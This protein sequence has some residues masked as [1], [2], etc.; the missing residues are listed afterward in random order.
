MQGSFQKRVGN[1]GKVTWTC[2]V[3]G[4]PDPVTG[5]RKQ[6]RL[7][8]STKRELQEQVTAMLHAAKSGAY[9]AP[10]GQLLREY[11]IGW[12]AGHKSQIRET[13][14]RSY[15]QLIRIHV[16]PKL[17]N[18]P[19]QKLTASALE[20][21]YADR[22]ASGLSPRTVQYLH[23]VIRTALQHAFRLGT[24]VRNVADMATAPRAP[25][26]QVQTWNSDQLRAFLGAAG[27]DGY[28]PA[29]LMAASTGLRRG[30]LLGLRWE[31]VDLAK[32]R[33][34]VRQAI[35]EVGSTLRVQEPK[36]KSGRRVVPFG[37]AV[38]TALKAHQAKQNERRLKLGTAWRGNAAPFDDLVFTTAVGGPIGPQNFSHRFKA[39][40]VA[41]GLP[42]VRL[43]DVRHAH[44][45][46][47][48]RDGI[49]AKVVSER[50]GH[51]SIALTLDTYSHVL[52]DMQDGAV[53]ATEAALFGPVSE[54]M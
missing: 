1:T 48:L 51:A 10:T 29:W 22:L 9:V 33:L 12:L 46:Q 53:L 52:P 23:R 16:L 34:H 35:V 50:L 39:L 45:T 2:V 3:D 36:T 41:A 7:S 30:E 19:L 40:T 13:T 49:A 8:A 25:R 4:P 27:D 20:A 32:G 28:A 43:H 38:S 37:P 18:V 26:A 6:R 54:A 21:F 15:E 44:A 47:L 17:G 31:D 5:K 14:Y 42:E 11:L 24:V